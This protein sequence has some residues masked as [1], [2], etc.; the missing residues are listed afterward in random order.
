MMRRTHN[1]S[2]FL[3]M[4]GVRQR[5][6]LAVQA[7]FGAPHGR[8][9]IVPLQ[10]EDQLEYLVVEIFIEVTKG[11]GNP[12]AQRRPIVIQENASVFHKRLSGGPVQQVIVNFQQRFLLREHIRKVHPWADTD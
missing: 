12:R 1:N 9:Q 10:S 3:C 11:P 8:P 5:M 2:V 6:A 4:H 7:E